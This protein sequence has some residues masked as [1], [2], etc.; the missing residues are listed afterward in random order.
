MSVF[1]WFQR[2][3]ASGFGYRSTA[4]DVTRDVDLAGKT[5]LLTG[6]TSGLG[7]EALRVLTMRGARVIGTART[8][9]KARAAGA[10]VAVACEL[11]DPASVR[12]CVDAVAREAPLDAIICNAGIM[13]PAK[14]ELANG[15][16]L[17]FATNHVGHFMLVTGLIERLTER[18]RVVIVASE[19]H[20]FTPKGGIDFDNLDGSRGYSRFRTYGRSKLANVLFAK[21]LARRFAAAGS[22]RT[23]NALHPGTIAT[24][25]TRSSG[26]AT[27]AAAVVSPLAMKTVGEG[28][29]TEVFVATHPSVA[30]VS[31]EYFDNCNVAKAR[32]LAD[33]VP[34]AAR[35]W[36]ETEHIVARL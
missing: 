7:A 20:R 31:G 2:A 24:R 30:T 10:T 9:D 12:A 19:G 23:A 1:G 18:G 32:R 11:A 25:L 16:E 3:G 35:L 5:I 4:E 8:L 36:T 29:A 22:A 13:A 27:A 17:Q 34:L 26:V 14:L 28:A 6:C 21:Q 15:L 33:D